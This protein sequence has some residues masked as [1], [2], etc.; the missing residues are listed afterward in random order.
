MCSLQ[1][2]ESLIFLIICYHMSSA[3]RGFFFFFFFVIML[4]TSKKLGRHIGL[5]LSVHS[6]MSGSHFE[7]GQEDL[8]I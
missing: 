7:Y 6:C 8:E 2:L 4:P 5:G 3:F 1:V